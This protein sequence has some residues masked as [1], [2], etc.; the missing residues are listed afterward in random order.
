MIKKVKFCS[1]CPFM[2]MDEN[3]DTSCK[4]ETKFSLNKIDIDT[5]IHKDCPLK[6]EEITITVK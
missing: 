2:N 1:Q 3:W 6:K 5:Q 4:A